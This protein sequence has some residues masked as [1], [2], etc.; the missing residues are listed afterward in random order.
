MILNI[1]CFSYQLFLITMA[2]KNKFK[3]GNPFYI[4]ITIYHEFHDPFSSIVFICYE[5]CV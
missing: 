2:L 3:V 1:F 4:S 5:S